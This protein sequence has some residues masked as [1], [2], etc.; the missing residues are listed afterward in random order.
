MNISILG[1]GAYGIA[2]ALMFHKNGNKVKMWTKFE[3]ERDSILKNR[4]N[5]KVLPNVKIPK[6][7]EISCDFCDLL[8]MLVVN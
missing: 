8:M 5:E 6:D 3:E 4:I 2:L 7:I 1:T